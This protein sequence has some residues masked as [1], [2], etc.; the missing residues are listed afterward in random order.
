TQ[1][2]E[3]GAGRL[4]PPLLVV[5]REGLLEIDEEFAKR[6]QAGFNRRGNPFLSKGGLDLTRHKAAE[7]LYGPG[8]GAIV[9]RRKLNRPRKAIEPLVKRRRQ[10]GL[11]GRLHNWA[12][13]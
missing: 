3:N 4:K 2:S 10:A 12:G 7:I 13:S 1:P 8:V 6:T 11:G 5:D 9:L